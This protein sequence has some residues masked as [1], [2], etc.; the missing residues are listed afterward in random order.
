MAAMQIAHHPA[1]ALAAHVEMIW[2]C[3]GYQGSIARTLSCRTAASIS[4]VLEVARYSEPAEGSGASV[5]ASGN[6]K[7]GGRPG[8]SS[9]G[10]DP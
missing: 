1:G 3:D 9:V 10:D 7:T 6:D 2:Y 8:S 5:L 4:K